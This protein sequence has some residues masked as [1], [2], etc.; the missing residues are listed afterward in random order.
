VTF[1]LRFFLHSVCAHTMPRNGG[2]EP[3][4]AP[5]A[6][7]ALWRPEC[8]RARASAAPGS[9]QSSGFVST[10][11]GSTK[12]GSGGAL[13]QHKARSA[14]AATGGGASAAA[15]AAAYADGAPRRSAAPLPGGV[16]TGADAVAYFARLGSEAPEKFFYFVRCVFH[17]FIWTRA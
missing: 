3:H 5:A 8:A 9:L 13:P 1:L 15:T 6:A 16:A 10:S 17:F 11:G 14:A 7:S 4:A 12:R 2:E